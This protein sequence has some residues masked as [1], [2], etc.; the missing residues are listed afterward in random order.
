MIDKNSEFLHRY[1]TEEDQQLFFTCYLL[2]PKDRKKAAKK[3]SKDILWI[4]YDLAR[5]GNIDMKEEY[6]NYMSALTA[7][8]RGDHPKKGWITLKNMV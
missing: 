7:F 6:L 5:N 8:L 1:L 4:A 2:P 3:L